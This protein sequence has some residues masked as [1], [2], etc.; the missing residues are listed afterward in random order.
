[1]RK[2]MKVFVNLLTTLRLFIT[3]ILVFLFR[4]ISN[5][6]FLISIAILFLTDFIDGKLA[7]KYKVQ[8][9]YG[10]N[11]DTIADKALSI[12]LILILINKIPILWILLLGEIAI[13]IINITGKLQGKRTKSS[14]IGKIK[15]WL[16]AMAIIISYMNYFNM[17]PKVI[18]TITTIITFIIQIIVIYDYLNFLKHQEKSSRN[19][20]F[21]YNGIKDL[22][23]K[24]FSTEYYLKHN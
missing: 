9:L 13:S 24:L 23:Y 7:R 8:T 6:K 21:K 5:L 10:S 15:T 20:I 1:M 12:M 18:V 3:I 4:N 11:M 17:L 16:I 19:H 22:I 14:L 2:F